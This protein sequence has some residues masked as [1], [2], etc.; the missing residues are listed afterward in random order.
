MMTAQGNTGFR[1]A[2]VQ[3]TPSRQST[4]F[5]A[6]GIP[7]SGDAAPGSSRNRRWASAAC[8]SN[9]VLSG[10]SDNLGRLTVYA[11][12]Q[13]LYRSPLSHTQSWFR[14]KLPILECNCVMCAHIQEA[15][16]DTSA[17]V[18]TLNA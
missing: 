18:D 12:Q 15:L 5:R 1:L 10:K 4:S 6:T 8:R 13:C 3:A 16:P 14:L 7:H 9:G 17:F 11:P 2:A